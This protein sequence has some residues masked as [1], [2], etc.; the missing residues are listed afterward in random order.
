VSRSSRDRLLLALAAALVVLPGLGLRDLWNPDE[1]RYGE[2]AREMRET[3]DWWVPHL[4]GERY[5]EK[6]PLFFWAIAVA[7]VP[8]GE[9]TETAVRLPSALAAIGTLLLVFGIGERR[10]GRRAAW[11]AAAALG[12]SWTVAWHARF[13]QIDMLLTFLVTL[14]VWCWSREQWDGRRGW[15]LGFFAATGLATVA[16]GPAGFLPPLLAILAFLALT[17]DREGFRRLRLGRGFLLWAAVVLGWLV[18]ASLAA[19]PGYWQAM[20][21]KQTLTRY[22]E[23]WHHHQP[24]YYYLTVIPADFFPWA[25]LLPGALVAGWCGLVRP[26]WEGRKKKL[27][28]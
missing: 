24:W 28:E 2:V 20:I 14:G 5:T 8:F 25:F 16:K 23:P 6:P 7:S 1:A 3:G 11:F 10:F 17:R 26:W 15:A 27:G 4:N 9:V 19:G 13:G 21:F 22:A 18:P 12:T